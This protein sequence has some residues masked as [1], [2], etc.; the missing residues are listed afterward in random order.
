LLAIAL[1]AAVIFACGTLAMDAF[2]MVPEMVLVWVG[3]TAGRAIRFIV[4][5]LGVS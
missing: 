2:L 3:T 4:K 5:F 1:L